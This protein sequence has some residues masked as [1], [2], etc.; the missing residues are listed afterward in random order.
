MYVLLGSYDV[1]KK[2]KIKVSNL[3]IAPKLQKYFSSNTTELPI[4]FLNYMKNFVINN[5]CC[6]LETLCYNEILPCQLP[7]TVAITHPAHFLSRGDT[8]RPGE[9]HQQH[10]NG[11]PVTLGDVTHVGPSPWHPRAGLFCLPHH[12]LQATHTQTVNTLKSWHNGPHCADNIFK[13]NF[14]K[15]KLYILMKISQNY[16]TRVLAENES[17]HQMS[18]L[19]RFPA[20]KVQLDDPAKVLR[21]RR[22]RWHSHV[23]RSDCWLKKV[24]RLNPAGGHGHGRP[25]KT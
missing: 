21:T 1:L 16:V 23:E 7:G 11:R 3:Y 24:Q 10:L 9:H 12:A 13:C 20:G 5:Q 6:S 18:Q 14:C 4:K 25:K 17:C 19:A 8:R 22:L 2:C 15:E